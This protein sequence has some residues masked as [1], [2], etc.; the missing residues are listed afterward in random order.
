MVGLSLANAAAAVTGTF[1]VNGSPTKTQ[2]VDSA[3]GRSQMSQLTT[4]VVVLLVLLFL[5]GPLAYLPLAVLATVVFLIGIELI[6]VT[7]MRQ[8][9]AV[10]RDEF[11]IALLTAI[12]VVLVGVEQGIVLA[13]AV[14]VPRIGVEAARLVPAPR[15]QRCAASAAPVSLMT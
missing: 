7:G 1:V 12:V 9:L 15:G 5:T 4:A 3:G 2:M 11:A 13:I 8:I 10:R 14:A 6:N